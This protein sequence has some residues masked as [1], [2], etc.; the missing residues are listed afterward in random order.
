MFVRKKPNKSGLVSVQVIDKTTG[1]YRVVKTLGLSNDPEVIETLIREGKNYIQGQT[2]I[3]QIDFS[4]YKTLYSQVLSSIETHKLVGIE[5]VLGK[6]FNEIGFNQI[7]DN[8]FRDLVL[9]R[10][11]YPKSKLRTSEYLQRYEQ[12]T[13]SED[14]IYRY[15]DKLHSVQKELVQQ[16]SYRHT[17]K[18][19]NGEIQAVFYDVTT[20]YFEV[21]RDDD[22]RKTGFS[23]EGKHQHPQI[24]LG[25]LVSKGA[26]PLAYEIFEGNKY[27]GDT[28]LPILDKF[29]AKYHFQKLTVVADAGLLSNNNVSQLMENGYEF[30]L[31]ARIKNETQKIKE[32]ILNLKL[33]NG[34]CDSLRK[35]D[36]RLLI[37]YSEDRARKDSYN[38]EKGL[39]RLENL[40]RSGK[41]TK[42][43]INNKGYNK[44]LKLE[45]EISVAI[46]QSRAKQDALW[47]GL[48]G[49]LT[50]SNLTD[51]EVL[52]NYRHLWQ[53]E[54]AFRI[55]KSEL[56][57]RPIYHYKQRRIEAH[58]CLNFTAY[59]V[60]KELE[61]QLKLKKSN[62]SAEKV[63]EIIQTIYQISLYTPSNELI[64][65]TIILTEEQRLVQTL[66]GF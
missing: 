30:I 59:K 8:L 29:K 32:E 46:D 24:V 23:K 60:Y 33:K 22:L 56:K 4:D 43:S 48:K 39:K 17:L 2:G 57:I 50:N 21:E 13:Y 64:N 34:E 7:E 19:L 63:I 20:I 52:E 26:Y 28:F 9:Y 40:I 12:K 51:Q 3:Q 31:G 55:A 41:L 5:Y 66:F 6:I 65:K 38:R 27:E 18:V 11:I 47:D 36:L 14:D 44:F 53:I 10:L 45:G 49:Y 54:K 35:G 15:M 61:R 37:T 42:S 62:L 58:I 25:L 1:R 16:I